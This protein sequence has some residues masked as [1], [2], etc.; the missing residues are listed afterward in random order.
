MAHMSTAGSVAWASEA[1][2]ANVPSGSDMTA[3]RPSVVM[4]EPFSTLR[5][6]NLGPFF[7]SLQLKNQT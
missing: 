1:L 2:C 4:T 6:T 7:C 5:I 3:P